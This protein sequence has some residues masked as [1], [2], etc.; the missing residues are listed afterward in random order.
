MALDSIGEKDPLYGLALIT[1]ALHAPPNTLPH[2]ES[3]RLSNLIFRSL[4]MD[5]A[6]AEVM[7]ALDGRCATQTERTPERFNGVLLDVLRHQRLW[8]LY[9]RS[10]A[11]DHHRSI[12]P[13]AYNERRGMAHP[14]E[15]ARWRADFRAMAPERQM[16]AAT[17]VWLYQSGPDSTWLRR[18]PCTWSATEALRYLQDAGCLSQWLQLL[19]CFPGW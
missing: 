6:E 8:H 13:C 19:A 3:V 17:I 10:D 12:T 5:Q 4:D 15:M 1:A 14:E 2:F 18:V 11:G 16:M 9:C 7:S